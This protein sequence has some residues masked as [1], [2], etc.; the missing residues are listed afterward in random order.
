M[1]KVM[2]D[3]ID[4][5]VFLPGQDRPN[6]LGWLTCATLAHDPIGYGG[7]ANTIYDAVGMGTPVVTSPGRFHRGGWATM[8][9]ERLGLSEL[10]EGDPVTTAVQ[11][12]TQPERVQAIRSRP[13]ASAG[14]L[15]EDPQAIAEHRELF[16]SGGISR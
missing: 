9:L 4:R 15:L 5:M 8:T 3:A 12:L 2:G 11:L 1:A 7:G 13:K 6:Y 14:S 16:M 10:A